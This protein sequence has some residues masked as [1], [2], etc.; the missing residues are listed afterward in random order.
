MTARQSRDDQNVDKTSPGTTTHGVINVALG[1]LQRKIDQR[2]VDIKDN[3][4][5]VADVEDD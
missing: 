2:A 1:D 3:E 4:D 5:K